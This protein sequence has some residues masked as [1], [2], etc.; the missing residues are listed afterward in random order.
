MTTVNIVLVVLITF[1]DSL[2]D[3]VGVVASAYPGSFGVRFLDIN[4]GGVTH[5]PWRFTLRR[6]GSFYSFQRSVFSPGLLK[7]VHLFLAIITCRAVATP[8]VWSSHLFVLII[9]DAPFQHFE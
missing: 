3:V 5:F 9:P 7:A 1:L 4:I 6:I 8:C 2:R